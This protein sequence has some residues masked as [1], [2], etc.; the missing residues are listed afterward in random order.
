LVA[1]A[2]IFA[3]TIISPA[4]QV[5]FLPSFTAF[6]QAT[7]D[8]VASGELWLKSKFSMRTA[9]YHCWNHCQLFPSAIEFSIHPARGSAE[10]AEVIEL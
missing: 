8:V 10:G 4:E 3:G 1:K 9:N 7:C 6:Y 5:D 2:G